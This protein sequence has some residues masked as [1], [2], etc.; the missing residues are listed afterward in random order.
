MN[1]SSE[2][3]PCPFRDKQALFSSIFFVSFWAP[4]SCL[5][6]FWFLRYGEE[7]LFSN[8]VSLKLCM[9]QRVHT[10]YLLC[11]NDFFICKLIFVIKTDDLS[12]KNKINWSKF[13]CTNVY[14]FVL[15]NTKKLVF[16][17]C[18]IVNCLDK[19]KV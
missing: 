19:S 9:Y 6:R 4:C 5:N 18:I 12:P 14:I 17:F 16:L 11:T 7:A 1:S 2:N 15:Q 3:N 10:C 13:L 8:F